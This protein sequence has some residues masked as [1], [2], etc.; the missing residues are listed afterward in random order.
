MRIKIFLVFLE[1]KN[2]SSLIERSKS[3]LLYAN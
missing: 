2:N 3:I 1:I